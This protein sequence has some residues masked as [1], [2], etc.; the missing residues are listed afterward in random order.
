MLVP[1]SVQTLPTLCEYGGIIFC[2]IFPAVRGIDE[3][4]NDN[5][6]SAELE[7]NSSVECMLIIDLVTPEGMDVV[8]GRRGEI[9]GANEVYLYWMGGATGCGVLWAII[10]TVTLI[11]LS[12]LIRALY[13]VEERRHRPAR[14][15]QG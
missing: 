10:N 7:S 12:E 15:A 9:R 14:V 3:A 13:K 4:N 8:T 11:V 1:R 5:S 6:C 2:L